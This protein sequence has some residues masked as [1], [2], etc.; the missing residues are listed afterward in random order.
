MADDMCKVLLKKVLEAAEEK[1]AKE[2]EDKKPSIEERKRK[3]DEEKKKLDDE[4]AEVSTAKGVRWMRR[5][6]RSGWRRRRRMM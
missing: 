2:M 4:L 6:R 1:V 5:L 3:L